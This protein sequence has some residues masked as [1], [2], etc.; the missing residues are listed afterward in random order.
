MKQLGLFLPASRQKL[1]VA[2][3]DRYDSGN[4]ASAEL[5]LSDTERWGGEASALVVWA[6][7]TIER[8]GEPG[9]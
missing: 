6:R 9:R 1:T 5:I 4:L 8:L 2:K 7:L 3:S